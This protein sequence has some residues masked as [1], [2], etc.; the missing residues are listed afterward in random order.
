MKRQ[1]RIRRKGT[2]PAG[3]VRHDPG[4]ELDDLLLLAV[5]ADGDDLA[6][7]IGLN[8][9]VLEMQH[10]AS[11]QEQVGLL[12]ARDLLALRTQREGERKKRVLGRGYER[13]DSRGRRQDSP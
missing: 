5:A 6:L 13:W 1:E 7:E 3:E 9:G 11:V 12:E 4:Q 10:S 2:Y 8:L